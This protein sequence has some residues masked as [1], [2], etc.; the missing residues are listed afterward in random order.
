MICDATYAIDEFRLLQ[1]GTGW[2][3][4]LRGWLHARTR[5]VREPHRSMRL[6]VRA[7]GNPPVEFPLEEVDEPSDDVASL[8]G[9]TAASVR[10]RLRSPLID[11]ALPLAES[12]LVAVLEH[13]DE[14]SI[15]VGRLLSGH[16][17]WRVLVKQF[18]S[19]GNNCELGLLQR[20]LGFERM[21]LFRF[22]GS[23]DT[24]AV[25]R[26]IAADFEGLA[27]P[28]DLE[29]GHRGEEW[30]AVSR[31]YALE[32]HTWRTRSELSEAQIRAAM[33]TTL[34][35]QIEMFRELMASGERIFVRRVRRSDNID[36]L[37]ELHAALRLHGPT[38]LLWVTD[39]EPGEAHAAIERLGDGFYRGAHASMNATHW[40]TPCDRPAWL[41]LLDAAARTIAGDRC[42]RVPDPV[43]EKRPAGIMGRMRWRGAR[44]QA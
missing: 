26:A 24:R 14:L 25:A 1:D 44:L 17:A 21:G 35:Y 16:P 20:D 7:P 33:S 4:L 23:E 22:A 38:Q 8:L 34:G 10:F 13:G 12:R 3:I 18:E 30:I 37:A 32:V 9:P 39:P 5:S 29:F 27:T 6:C 11:I 19:I 42:V 2:R 36:G 41:S 40:P 31:R 28:D 15:D 43:V